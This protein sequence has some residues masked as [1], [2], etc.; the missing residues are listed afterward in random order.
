MHEDGRFYDFLCHKGVMAAV[1]ELIQDVDAIRLFPNY[2]LRPKTNLAIH[3]VIWHQDAGLT[4]S[5][6]PNDASVEARTDA[7]GIGTTVRN[8]K[9]LRFNTHRGGSGGNRVGVYDIR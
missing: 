3:E 2:S 5:G 6:A 9:Q 7:F 8:Y 4:P 1:H